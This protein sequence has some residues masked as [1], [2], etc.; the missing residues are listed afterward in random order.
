MIDSFS[1][2]YD[3]VRNFFRRRWGWL[4]GA[5]ILYF[6]FG[7]Y[8]A[9]FLGYA[10]TVTEIDI[11]NGESI[12]KETTSWLSPGARLLRDLFIAA[13]AVIGIIMAGWRNF[14]LD[15][16]SKAALEQA[17]IGN[18][19]AKH[20]KDRIAGERFSDAVKLLSQKDTANKPAIDAR[21]GG[22]YSL[23]MLANNHIVEYGAQV[24]KTLIAYIKQ[25]AQPPLPKETRALGENMINLQPGSSLNSGV[26][27]APSQKQACDIGEDVKAAFKVLEQLLA[28][29]KKHFVEGKESPDEI[30]LSDQ[31]LNFSGSN[32]SSLDMSGVP[33]YRYKWN[34]VNMQEARLAFA[35][36]HE[37]DLTFA[38][39]Q[40]TNLSEANLQA[41]RLASAN[42]QGAGLEKAMLQGANL[43]GANLQAA[44][45][46]SANLQGA[47]LEKAMLQGAN[48]SGANLQ[49]ARLASANLQSAGLEK[50]MLQ[51]AMLEHANLKGVVLA[52]A[53]LESANL[54]SAEMQG[55]DLGGA[56][57]Q[58]ANLTRAQL[59]GATLWEADLRGANLSEAIL[60]YA[61]LSCAKLDDKTVLPNNLSGKI[62][63][64]GQPKLSGITLLSQDSK[65]DLSPF[66]ESGHAL[67]GVLRN[68]ALRRGHGFV[69]STDEDLMRARK[70]RIVAHKLLYHQKLPKDFPQSWQDWLTKVNSDGSHPDDSERLG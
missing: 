13:A 41:A 19:Q 31:D 39:L 20:D 49:T 14:A 36:L 56:I 10:E 22:I 66:V 21:I 64:S 60:Q 29:H 44:R 45:L 33:L 3:S 62:W 2:A 37:A 38:N 69:G 67:V 46:A 26:L 70:L 40:N 68:Y 5:L 25:N 54:M 28:N 15:R 34:S 24:V 23:Q 18:K 16:Q 58:N 52:K 30:K 55:A 53:R 6:F 57:M 35:D 42:L 50:A 17:K 51:N 32:F 27:N 59:Q 48:L 4:V 61:D 47:G 1:S 63:H 65:W 43:S 8:L 9:V 7:D 11:K 12:S